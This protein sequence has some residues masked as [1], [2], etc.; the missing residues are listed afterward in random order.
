VPRGLVLCVVPV[1]VAACAAAP[2]PP[3]ADSPLVADSADLAA[4]AA[5][6][7]A[8]HPE[9]DALAAW[10]TTLPEGSLEQRAARWL[11]AWLPPPD[12]AALDLVTLVEHVTFAC[13]GRRTAPWRDQL[14]DDLW[15]HYVV[16][17]RVSQEPVQPWRALLA[18]ELEP[19]VAGCASMEEAALAVNRWCRQQ[20]TY[21]PTS[22]RDM[23]PLTT[24]ARGLG[25]CEEEMILTIC[26]LRA[27][28]L[29]ARPCSTPYWTF[30]D[31]N[32]AWVEVWA[33]GR[34]H[35]AESCDDRGCLDNA[36]FS[37]PA[38]RA[39][40]VRSLAYGEFEPAGEPLYRAGDGV[41]IV[42]STAVYTR[43]FTLQAAVDGRPDAPVHVNV[44]NYG[45]LRAIARVEPG[46]G[47]DLGPGEYALTAAA[48]DSTLWLRVVRGEPGATV[49]VT[50]GPEDRYDLDASPPFWLRYPEAAARP[51]RSLD[52]VPAAELARH[53]E[54]VAAR[55][56]ERRKLRQLDPAEQAL[57]DSLPPD[58]RAAWDAILAKPL[59]SPATWVRL[60]PWAATPS[61][62]SALTAFLGEADDKDL[63]EWTER[64]VRAHVTAALAVR[65]TL[66]ASWGLSLPDS[67]WREGVLTGRIASEPGC[68][69]RTPLPVWRLAPTA[70]A[71]LSAWLAEF[72]ARLTTAPDGP[73]G[74][75]LPPHRT[76]RVGTARRSDLE[77]CFVGLCRRAGV[78]A[79]WRHGRTEIWDGDWREVTVI[80]ADPAAGVLPQAPA[81]ARGGWLD[82][83]LT[84]GRLPV[85]SA[86]AYRHFM[87]AELGDGVLEHR[88][89]DLQSGLQPWDAGTYVLGAVTRVPGGSV[90]GRLR[91][92]RVAAGD[93]TRV[94]LPLD[95]DASGWDP[96]SLVD[97]TLLEP[98]D[99]ALRADGA[100]IAAPTAEPV[101]V[102]LAYPGEDLARSLTALGRVWPRLARDHTRLAV[103]LGSPAEPG[104]WRERLAAANLPADPPADAGP[105]LAAFLAGEARRGP[106]IA[107]RDRGGEWRLLRTGLDNELDWTIHLALDGQD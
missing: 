79:R 25:R 97:S 82:V 19:L 13:H 83:T 21:T 70:D 26:A 104:P 80:A 10:F 3:P 38:S 50:L 6:V 42:N 76:W 66:Q 1:L 62:R 30:T 89:W 63:L 7:I 88:W 90:C 91:S 51:V 40:F 77:V 8:A 86:E 14:T 48:P 75:P 17:H 94:A 39:G 67:I 55:D 49:A 23:G 29:P 2:L 34:W 9:R 60:L 37:G 33:D 46:A 105:A 98:L 58:L 54:L 102:V 32:H 103:H 106:L 101:L 45:T 12:L 99:A 28:G 93:T 27:A 61:R 52:F 65:D 73:L 95:V 57:L 107:L 59:V 71:T 78:P 15:L 85:G 24:L 18:R 41:T 68:D 35:Y 84:R 4:R 22:N 96:A 56:A 5:A 72:R 16:P 81:V 69:W 74:Q 53:R 64:D 11:L 100:A 92:F 36:W 43:P 87:V 44:L 47:L 20:A 31:D